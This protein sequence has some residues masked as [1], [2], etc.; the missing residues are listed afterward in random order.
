M[1]RETGFIE[2]L[3]GWIGDTVTVDVCVQPIRCW[4][5]CR[6]KELIEAAVG[7]LEAEDEADESHVV[8]DDVEVEPELEHD[9]EADEYEADLAEADNSD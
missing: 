3:V 7:D 1:F 6:A 8:L 9:D 4:A 2:Q 5:T